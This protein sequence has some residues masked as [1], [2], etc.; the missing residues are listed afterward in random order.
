[1]I[2][3]TSLWLPIL[4]SA[5]FVWIASAI[6]WML[7]PYHK[8]DFKGLPD[9]E[10]AR[11]ALKPQDIKPGQYNIPNVK[12]HSECKNPDVIKKFEE[13]PVG[14]LTILPKGMPSMGKNIVL[15]FIFYVIVGIFVAYITS[16]TV[17]SGAEYLTV[18]RVTGT[19][20]FLAYG[21]AVIPDSIWFGR[22]WSITFKH[23][24][25]A[26][27]YALLTAGSFSWLWAH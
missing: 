21:T 5:V 7:L 17:S 22:P 24:F 10:A 12:S 15:S 20:A 19:V 27:I 13:G 4:L 26:L 8:S 2:E 6:I 23:L 3:L 14:Y 25:D 9:E 18:F 1:M 16:R 11:N